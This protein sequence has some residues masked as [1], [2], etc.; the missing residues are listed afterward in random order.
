MN[1]AIYIQ[2]KRLYKIQ[3]NKFSAFRTQQVTKYILPKTDSQ[4]YDF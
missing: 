2:R 3:I 1:L 4:F